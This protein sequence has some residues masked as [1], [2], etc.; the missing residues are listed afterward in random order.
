M[1]DKKV[2]GD[3]EEDVFGV[4]C[5]RVS[6]QI[7]VGLDVVVGALDFAEEVEVFGAELGHFE[8]NLEN[9]EMRNKKKR[10]QIFIYFIPERICPSNFSA[11]NSPC[12]L[13]KL[14]LKTE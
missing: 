14:G 11:L 8:K 4:G 9:S 2:V 12:I 3:F 10:L 6:D 7:V 5:V 1:S 13:S